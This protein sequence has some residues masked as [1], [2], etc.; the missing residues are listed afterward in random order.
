MSSQAE[1]IKGI[2]EDLGDLDKKV[3]DNTGDIL[4]LKANEK[5][6]YKSLQRIETK[7]DK[8]TIMIMSALISVIIGLIIFAVKLSS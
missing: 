7:Q 1:D 8:S 5:N 6:N 4:T 3:E 2:K